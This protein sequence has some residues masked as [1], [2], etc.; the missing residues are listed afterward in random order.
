MLL[1]IED[2]MDLQGLAD[3]MGGLDRYMA[4]PPEDV[5]YGSPSK[6]RCSF[7]GLLLRRSVPEKSL[8]GIL[9]SLANFSLI[10]SPEFA[11]SNEIISSRD[12][13]VTFF[14]STSSN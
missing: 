1:L 4:R 8:S 13:L 6:L 9:M 14:P 2:G 3:G 5:W 10:T 11:C 7:P 12:M